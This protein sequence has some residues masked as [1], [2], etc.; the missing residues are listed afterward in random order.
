MKSRAYNGIVSEIRKIF[1]SH[2]LIRLFFVTFLLLAA[3][4]GLPF[5]LS[6]QDTSSNGTR[7][8]AEI[9]AVLNRSYQ[10]LLTRNKQQ[11]GFSDLLKEAQRGWLKYVDLHMNSVFPLMNG[12]NPTEVYGSNYTAEYEEEKSK[13]YLQRISLL[14][15]M[16]VKGVPGSNVATM[17]LKPDVPQPVT[18]V[19]TQTGIPPLV[20]GLGIG[21]SFNLLS[22]WFDDKLKDTSVGYEVLDGGRVFLIASEKI[23]KYLQ[24]DGDKA[25]SALRIEQLKLIPNGFAETPSLIVAGPD[26]LVRAISLQPNLVNY[27][28]KSQDVEYSEFRA[29]FLE[30][31]KLNSLP[32]QDGFGSFSVTTKDGVKFTV[33]SDKSLLI[34]R[35]V[36]PEKV[37]GAFD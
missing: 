13:L 25:S 11:P 36:E 34:E 20:K 18:T 35:V 19:P 8:F 30:S 17:P 5:R 23:L 26:G 27:L 2:M 9:D 16:T 21:M 4:N 14:D 37:K 28:F 7:S 33:E 15:G 3:F 22:P 31:Y 29:L 10:E 32:R 1:E 12:E 24:K 6:A